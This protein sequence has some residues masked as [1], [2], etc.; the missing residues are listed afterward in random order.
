MPNAKAKGSKGA[1]GKRAASPQDEP[2]V[3]IL[4]LCLGS[5]RGYQVLPAAYSQTQD[6]LLSTEY[7]LNT[8]V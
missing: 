3:H 4:C 7:N 8:T 5:Q 2:Q 1:K 6:L